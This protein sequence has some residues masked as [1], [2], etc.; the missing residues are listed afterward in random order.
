MQPQAA[1]PA[2]ALET[3]GP[4]FD[5]DGFLID[6]AQW[7]KTLAEQLA[8]ASDIHRLTEAHW[9]TIHFV[10]D[11]YLRLGAMPPMRHVCRQIGAKRHEIKHLF[12]GC[13]QLWQ[14][15]GLP[16]PGEE[17]KAYMD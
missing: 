7:T 6:T 14:I 4:A 12:G 2:R 8:E 15:S 9:T 10:R 11:K 16:N 17:A 3:L 1:I 13:R 5:E